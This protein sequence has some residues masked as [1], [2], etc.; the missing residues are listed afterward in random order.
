MNR[1][2]CKTE[3]VRGDTVMC[4]CPDKTTKREGGDVCICREGEIGVVR[5]VF[6]HDDGT[7]RFSVCWSDHWRVLMRAEEIEIVKRGEWG[8][9]LDCGRVSAEREIRVH[10]QMINRVQDQKLFE[11]FAGDTT[12]CSEDIHLLQ[13]DPQAALNFARGLAADI[14]KKRDDNA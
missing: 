7:D 3:I 1:T 5:L 11:L 9:Y 12:Y 8:I 2:L 4:M 10:E 6:R 13:H 14:R